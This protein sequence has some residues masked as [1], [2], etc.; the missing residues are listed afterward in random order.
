MPY[1]SEKLL[2]GSDSKKCDEIWQNRQKLPRRAKGDR[3]TPVFGKTAVN[4]S[5]LR[6]PI[7]GRKICAIKP[8]TYYTYETK[9]LKR[10]RG[11]IKK[12]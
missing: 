2:A 4:N 6:G 5:T 12:L 9:V 7:K 3:S 1:I 10:L 8:K 11:I